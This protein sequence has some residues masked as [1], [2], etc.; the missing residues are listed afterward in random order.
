MDADPLVVRLRTGDEAAF[1]TLVRRY[2][3]HLLAHAEFLVR[4]HA[5]AEEV[6][7]DTWTAVY[8]GI[9]RFEGRSSLLTWITRILVNRAATALGRERRATPLG[10][11]E[12]DR[13]ARPSGV[14]HE[15]TGA[16][17]VDD[18]LTAQQAMRTVVRVLPQLPDAQ[19][20]VWTLHDIEH[21]TTSE[22]A[23]RLGVSASNQRVLLH[24]AR[25]RL[26]RH[27]GPELGRW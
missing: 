5:V 6:V 27:L 3:R 21:A 12:L 24:R 13:L 18:R 15:Y 19:R 4:N 1:T 8:T 26:R 11:D 7:Q 2:E 16:D 25:T 10:T 9:Q 20:S 14:G 22:V 23:A 17:A